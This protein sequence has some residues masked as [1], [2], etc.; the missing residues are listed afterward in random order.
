MA[1]G[2]L[3]LAIVIGIATIL[4]I[5]A[6]MLKQP[7][8]L[9]YIFTGVALAVV[10][11]LHFVEHGIFEAFSEL[12]IVFLLFLIGMEINYESVRLVGKVS[13]IL[14][15]SQILFTSLVGFAIAVLFGFSYLAATY[16]AVALTFSSTIIIVKLL[17]E[18]RE[19]HSLHGK[20][21][22]GFL[23]VQ[24][25]VAMLILIVLSGMET[26]DG[27][28]AASIALALTKGIALFVF[29]LWMGKKIMPPILD[30]IARSLELLFLTSLAWAIGVATAVAYAGFS[31]EIGGFLAG[32][33]L[34]NSSEHYQ[35]SSR[36]RSLRDF[37]ILLFFV[38]LGSSLIVADFTA[39]TLPILVFSLFVLIGN[40]LIVL[41]LMGLM[42]Y[43]K[44][45]S[46]MTGLTVAQISEFSL[47]VVALGRD[48][49][50][51]PA[52]V[53]SLVTSVGIAT[54]IISTY[55]ITYS[56]K[57]F[58]KIESLLGV[59]ERKVLNKHALP[60]SIARPVT[61]IGGHRI[62]HNIATAFPK[63]KILIIDFDPDIVH[64]LQEED[65]SVLFGDIS[66]DEIQEHAELHNTDMII[67][68]APDFEANAEILELAK[69]HE[70][71]QLIVVRAETERDAKF[72]YNKGADYVILTHLTAG[73][74]LGRQI[75][76]NYSK[77]HIKKL[78]EADLEQMRLTHKT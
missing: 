75:A 52:E 17:T 50:H 73:Q 38:S 55:A 41:V 46:F 33:A 76:E 43:R 27:I 71:D 62:G 16:I 4:G 1:T 72:F 67:S 63:E 9:A 60:D 7:A 78:K 15:L 25:F 68:T 42:G 18:K 28:T 70:K 14:G 57:I 53:L 35:I 51:V 3:E 64:H 74:S 13:L 31:I 44:K 47:I 12:G 5:I 61:I 8:F 20:I 10:P 45:T 59:F 26:G 65:Y 58:T 56:E 54:I 24:D 66:D 21:S 49:G 19:T 69:N 32:I 48:L 30:K 23:L 37:F 34:A 11:F 6:H 39:M 22:I 36:I 77:E 2:I 40:P 29:M